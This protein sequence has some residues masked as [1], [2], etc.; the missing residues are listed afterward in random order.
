MEI[1]SQ[2]KNIIHPSPYFEERI[3]DVCLLY[4]DT[5][6]TGHY[7]EILSQA[8]WLKKN[9][10]DCKFKMAFTHHPYFS[11]GP[12]HGKSEGFTNF[13]LENFVLGEFDYLI[14]GHEHILSDEGL[15]DGTRQIISGAGGKPQEGFRP[16][17]VVF[18]LV[19]D[20]PKMSTYKLVFVDEN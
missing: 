11:S 18:D 10:K 7:I 1:H 3:N 19:L 9:R 2:K 17:F 6:F 8:I 4:L 5:N 15:F 13:F 12:K 16:G 14:S 20:R